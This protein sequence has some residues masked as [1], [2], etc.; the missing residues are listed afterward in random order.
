MNYAKSVYLLT[1]KKVQ[2]NLAEKFLVGLG[3]HQIKREQTV[4]YLGVIIDEKFNWSSHVKHIETKLA[5][6]SNSIYK[7]RNILPINTPKLL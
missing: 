2:R 3:Y 1:G 5:F 6:A 4:K 7:T